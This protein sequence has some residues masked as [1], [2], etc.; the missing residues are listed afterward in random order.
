[1]NKNNLRILRFLISITMSLFLVGCTKQ[2]EPT[3]VS[4]KNEAND[5]QNNT[6]MI[7]DLTKS[8][9]DTELRDMIQRFIDHDLP[10]YYQGKLGISDDKSAD[11]FVPFPEENKTVAFAI[12][13]EA[14]PN[15]TDITLTRYVDAARF[16]FWQ[17]TGVSGVG[18]SYG[19]IINKEKMLVLNTHN[20]IDLELF[21][22]F[23]LVM[24]E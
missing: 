9:E 13:K 17:D 7:F 5:A 4:E 23:R 20:E 21:E 18:I 14:P 10:V 3:E 24:E 15:H 1:M 8:I 2:I 16:D 11:A 22:T 6:T 12:S 19:E